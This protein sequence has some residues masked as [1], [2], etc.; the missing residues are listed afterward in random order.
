MRF[1]G[2]NRELS[3]N[4][5]VRISFKLG[6]KM[7]SHNSWADVDNLR[8]ECVWF[9]GRP[10]CEAPKSSLNRITWISLVI[11]LLPAAHRTHGHHVWFKA[12]DGHTIFSDELVLLSLRGFIIIAFNFM[13]CPLNEI[14]CRLLLN[15]TRWFGALNQ[16]CLEEWTLLLTLIFLDNTGGPPL[17]HLLKWS[18]HTSM[19][20][21]WRWYFVKG[22]NRSCE[23]SCHSFWCLVV[24]SNYWCPFTVSV[25]RG[26]K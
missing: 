1:G 2:S 14:R 11:L 10:I 3:L 26:P 9:L 24:A 19:L 25:Q 20:L 18:E 12:R 5:L 16:A 6:L 15:S 21:R 8:Q 13:R 17:H 7:W 23:R 4:L 22:C